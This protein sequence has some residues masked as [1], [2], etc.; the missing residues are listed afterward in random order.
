MGPEGPNGEIPS[1]GEGSL[2]RLNNDSTF[3]KADTNIDI[4]NGIAWNLDDSKLYYIDTGTF[5]VDVFD[6]DIDTAI[7]S[8]F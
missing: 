5:R 6:Y 7:A 2:Y 1:G 8:E 4:S 3:F